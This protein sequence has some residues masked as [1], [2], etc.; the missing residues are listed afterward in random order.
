[1]TQT[2]IEWHSMVQN[3]AESGA[4]WHRM[5]TATTRTPERAPTRPNGL[6]TDS[7]RLSQTVTDS[8]GQSQPITYS[9]NS[10]RRKV[11]TK[12]KCPGRILCS[13]AGGTAPAHPWSLSAGC[14]SPAC[15][16]RGRSSL[17]RPAPYRRE[18]RTLHRGGDINNKQATSI[19]P[20]LKL[21][22]CEEKQKQSAPAAAK[23]ESQRPLVVIT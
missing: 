1:M 5:D 15:S 7:H 17:S 18:H 9:L 13:A 22:F 21:G 2:S 20:Q 3:G 4:Y 12:G 14:P 6:I 10:P 23:L 11:G 8:H 16:C 19:F